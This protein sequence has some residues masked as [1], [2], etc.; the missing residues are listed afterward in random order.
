MTTDCLALMGHMSWL[1]WLMP[2]A[3]LTLLGLGIAAL[4]KYLFTSTKPS[5]GARS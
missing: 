4:L 3:V 5:T 2:L 1:G